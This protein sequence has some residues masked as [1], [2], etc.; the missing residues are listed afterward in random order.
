ME[1]NQTSS[2]TREISIKTDLQ[3][4]RKEVETRNTINTEVLKRN[5]QKQHLDREEVKKRI[6]ELI[7]NFSLEREL[8]IHYD[9]DVNKLVITVV[10]SDSQK[11]IRQ[12]PDEETINF[13]RHFQ[14]YVGAL[15]NRRV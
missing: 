8:K 7:R 14:Q 15:I 13:I 11:V 12:I 10:D 5:I 1:T 6:E 3:K 2:I 4:S 9:E